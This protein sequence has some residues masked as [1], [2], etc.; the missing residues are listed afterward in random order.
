LIAIRDTG[1]VAVDEDNTKTINYSLSQNYPNPFNPITNIS[2]KI[3][4][5][6]LV[7]L[8]VY[9]ILGKEVAILV[10]EEQPQGNYSVKFDGSNL[11]SGVYVY[12]LRVNDFTEN[13][14]MILLR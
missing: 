5:K 3:K 14:K 1:T 12:S 9:D 4:E 6:G 7:Q 11:P 10:K 13:K 2:Y 8:K